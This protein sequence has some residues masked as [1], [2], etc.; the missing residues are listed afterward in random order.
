MSKV[1]GAVDSLPSLRTILVAIA[2]QWQ[3]RYGVAPQITAAL[4]EYD[5][6]R[7][8]G[9]P[10]AEYSEYMQDKTAVSKGVD[11]EWRGT[12]YQVKANRP[13]G[14]PG[15]RVTLVPKA[16]NYEWDWLVWILYN[17]EYEIQEAW[18]WSRDAYISAFDAKKRLSP[19]DYRRGEELEIRQ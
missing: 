4:S 1:S 18:K 8:V 17:T 13:S 16:A 5:A 10:D 14:K 6:S 3:R 9:M 15:S 2:L 19:N 12:K 11:F 7:L